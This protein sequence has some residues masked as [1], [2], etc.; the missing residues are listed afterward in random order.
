MFYILVNYCDGKEK[1]MNLVYFYICRFFI[2]C[3]D[4]INIYECL[5]EIMC[6][7]EKIGSCEWVSVYY[8]EVVIVFIILKI[9]GDLIWL[10]LIF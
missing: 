5:K 2:I 10:I 4:K 9:K 6:F 7:D 3:I 1:N 8:L